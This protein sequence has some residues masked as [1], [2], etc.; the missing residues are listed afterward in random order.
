M[1]KQSATLTAVQLVDIHGSRFCDVACQLEDG[2]AGS[3]RL[4]L[5]SVYADPK[6]GDAV[7]VSLLIGQLIFVQ[8]AG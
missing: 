1:E 6:V 7:I 2:R 8:K 3:G 5:E 4:G